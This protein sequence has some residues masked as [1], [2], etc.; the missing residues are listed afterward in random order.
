M[1][2]SGVT[3][4]VSGE[5]GPHRKEWAERKSGESAGGC[6]RA[7]WPNAGSRRD[8]FHKLNNEKQHSEFHD[9]EMYNDTTSRHFLSGISATHQTT[10]LHTFKLK[11]LSRKKSQLWI[12]LPHDRKEVGSRRQHCCRGRK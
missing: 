7:K 1:G 4:V 12:V 10:E 9:V 6:S 5:S 2:N 11:R 3:Q 8:D